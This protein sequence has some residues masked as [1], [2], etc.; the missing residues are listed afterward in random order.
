MKTHNA[1]LI[2]VKVDDPTIQDSNIVW[3]PF[4]TERE[5][6]ELCEY[7]RFKK[8][9]HISIPIAKTTLDLGKVTS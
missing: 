8:H 3:E 6:L 1:T 2:K 7:I 9:L 4:G 5:M